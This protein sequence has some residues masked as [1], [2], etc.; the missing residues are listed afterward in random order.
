MPTE[1]AKTVEQGQSVKEIAP[2]PEEEEFRPEG[3][4]DPREL[5]GVMNQFKDMRREIKRFLIQ[6]KK[7]P[8][9]ADESARLNEISG[10][11]NV[12]EQNLKNL[13]VD[14]TQRDA[15]QEFYDAQLWDTINEIRM[16]VEFPK[17]L[18]QVETELIKVEKLLKIKAF[19]KIEPAVLEA[20]KA[21]L[22][23]IREALNEAKTK[24]QAGEM[25]EA[26]WALQSIWEN[27]NPGD[28]NCLLYAFRDINRDLPRIKNKEIKAAIQDILDPVI[29]A[30]KDG[31]FREACQNFNEIRNEMW[32][33]MQYAFKARQTIDPA[34]KQKIQKL[35]QLIEEKFG[36]IGTKEMPGIP[37]KPVEKPSVE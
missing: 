32:K 3:W 6:L 29:Q 12:F 22:G 30:I 13:P 28:I 36:E 9:L 17:Q 21:K 7:I 26:Q 19:A 20:I 18:K 34:M 1:P 8:N 25:E 5:Q 35:Q 24:Y 31:D 15:L 2:P 11:L 4:V 37:E 23:E 33:V 16:K 10:Q 27:T 14:M